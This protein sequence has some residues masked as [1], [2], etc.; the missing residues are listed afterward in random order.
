[1]LVLSRRPQQSLLIGHD[2]VIT[3]LEVNGDTVR[4]GISAP[5]EVQIHR[6][7]VYRDLQ[8]SNREAAASPAGA[9]D[10]SR[11]LKPRR[12]DDDS[13]KTS[14]SPATPIPA[15]PIPA[16]PIPATPGAAVPPVVDSAPQ[17]SPSDGT[18]QS[19]E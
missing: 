15:T 11:Q 5:P 14:P 12:A 4:I 8:R 2:V 10:F 6:E 3:V 1:M 9:A 18:A 19:R 7:E 17:A 13:E 16:T